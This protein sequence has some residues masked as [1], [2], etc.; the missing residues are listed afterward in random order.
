MTPSEWLSH[1]LSNVVVALA[2]AGA[3]LAG[4]GTTGAQSIPP[5]DPNHNE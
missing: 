2:Q 1:N 5:Q 4:T 3:N